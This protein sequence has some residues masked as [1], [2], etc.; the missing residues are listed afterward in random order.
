MSERVKV[1]FPIEVED[2][3]PPVSGES[4]WAVHV[5]DEVYRLENTPFFVR[6]A[7]FGDLV[8][9]WR[10]AEGV[11]TVVS[12]KDEGNLTVRLIVRRDGRLEGDLAAAMTMVEK[13]GVS[14]EG[15][16]QWS[17]VALDVPEDADLDAVK[18]MVVAGE[19]D[20]L[21]H[22]EE[23]AVNDAWRALPEQV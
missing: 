20:G 8:Q 17:L 1:H 11:L 13:V 4:M 2:G 14:G 22:W 16:A 23:G 5:E 15:A 7:A 18:A 10:D 6:G 9:T 12:V 21:W 3:W 19:A